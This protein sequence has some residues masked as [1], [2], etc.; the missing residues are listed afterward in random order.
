MY[1]EPS[2]ELTASTIFFYCYALG[3]QPFAFIMHDPLNK[4]EKRFA[5]LIVYAGGLEFC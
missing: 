2:G 4:L 3:E 1:F 5:I